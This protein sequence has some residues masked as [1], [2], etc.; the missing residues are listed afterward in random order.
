VKQSVAQIAPNLTKVA[1]RSSRKIFAGYVIAGRALD[2]CRASL[3]QRAGSYH[4]DCPVDKMFFKFSG[5][6]SED[7]QSVAES[8]ASDQVIAEWIKTRSRVRD[9]KAVR[10][11]NRRFLW[12]PLTLLLDV[13]DWIHTARHRR[14]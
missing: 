5:I 2:K 10:R 7:F 12:N 14:R 11:W 4:Y 9:E 1:P 3:A 8:G 13:D 6:S